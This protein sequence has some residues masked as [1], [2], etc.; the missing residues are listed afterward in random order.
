MGNNKSHVFNPLNM[1]FVLFWFFFDSSTPDV[2]V[3]VRGQEVGGQEI[4]QDVC[5]SLIG[6]RQEIHQD[7]CLPL[8]GLD[9][10][11]ANHDSRTFSGNSEL[12]LARA[13]SPGQHLIKPC[14]KSGFKPW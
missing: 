1:V 9:G 10:H 6:Y 8:I 14:F 4:H 11:A 2:L 3:I 13:H 7:V 5:L 12:D